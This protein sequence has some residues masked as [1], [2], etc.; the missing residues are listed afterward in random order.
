VEPSAGALLQLLLERLAGGEVND[1]SRLGDERGVGS[2]SPL[3]LGGNAAAREDG[4]PGSRTA[5]AALVGSFVALC[6]GLA[7]AAGSAPVV[8]QVALSR[9][10]R[11]PTQYFLRVNIDQPFWR[12][13]VLLKSTE[14]AGYSNPA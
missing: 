12:P 8:S 11:A 6:S 5:G 1:G 2:A 7:G 4:V 10:T 9:T 14:V 13:M 3:E